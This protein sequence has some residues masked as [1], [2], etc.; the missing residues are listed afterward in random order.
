MLAWLIDTFAPF[1]ALAKLGWLAVVLGLFWWAE[2]H[3]ASAFAKPAG[4]GR[5]RRTN[6]QLLAIVM[7]LNFFA[8]AATV[9]LIA[10]GEGAGFGLF[11][12]FDWP[13]WVELAV[14]VLVL[15]LIALYSAHVLLHAVPALWRVHVVHH[16]DEHVDVT[17]GTR[18]HPLDF[19]LREV[20]ALMV[21][22]LLGMPLWVYLAYRA[23]AVA[24][25]Y[26]THANV[27]LPAKLERAL[28]YVIVTPRMHR[29]HHHRERPWTDTNFG[30]LFSFWDR[31]FGT[32]ARVDERELVYGVDCLDGLPVEGLGAQLSLPWRAWGQVKPSAAAAGGSADESSLSAVMK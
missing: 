13:A 1:Q 22:A 19:L 2:G 8:A 20:F 26:F 12:V 7:A 31:L 6:L 25:T 27:R 29:V 11:H 14:S 17:T 30:N 18:H 5:A 32:Y 10:W 16:A 15:D 23:L 9:A 24:F 21:V 3:Y 28:N 4:R